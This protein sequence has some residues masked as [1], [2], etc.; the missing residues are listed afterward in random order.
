VRFLGQ[1]SQFITPNKCTTQALN[2]RLYWAPSECAKTWH[3]MW[4]YM[5]TSINYKL[6]I[7]MSASGWWNKLTMFTNKTHGVNNFK[8]VMT[9][10]HSV[11]NHRLTSDFRGR[12]CRRKIRK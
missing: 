3:N 8:A 4:Q 1:H 11:R 2:E 10:S 5:H 6:E 12:N 7:G 9:K